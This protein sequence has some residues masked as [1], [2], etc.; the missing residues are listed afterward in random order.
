MFFISAGK[1]IAQDQGFQG[2][3]FDMDSKQRLT[4]VYIY[5]TRTGEGF[6]N[7]TKGEF[8]TTA[9]TG[10]VL[11][12]ALQGYGVDTISI[13]SEKTL[14]FYLRRNSIQL[15]EVVVR[16]SLKTPAEQLKQSQEEYNT[17]YTK[18]AVKDVFTTG[19][20][21]GGGGAGLSINAIYNLLS[22]EGKNAR[23][24]QK[25]IE[26]DYR[27][28]MIEYRFTRT[29]LNNVTGLSGAKLIDFKQQYKPGYYFILE[30]NDY[31]L[32]K[33]IQKSYL[34]YLGNPG[35]YRLGPLKG[36]EQ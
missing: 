32:I 3:V 5:N 12:A 7:T 33:Y 21:N 26:R 2:I 17:I 31:E 29:L 34:S 22:K 1:L 13:K 16:D 9:R 14:L 28:A 8:K 19:G 20:S 6:Y 24:L 18:G 10:D 27:D 30:A 23:M 15:Q 35:T 11:V 4:R 36:N 25:I